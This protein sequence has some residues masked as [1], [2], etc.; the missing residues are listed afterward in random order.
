MLTLSIQ[1]G[2]EERRAPLRGVGGVVPGRRVEAA[3]DR[4]MIPRGPGDQVYRVSPAVTMVGEVEAAPRGRMAGS[5]AQGGA[6]PGSSQTRLPAAGAGK[7]Q[8]CKLLFSWP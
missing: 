2:R 7:P 8:S 5:R 6:C 1:T 4:A 3:T